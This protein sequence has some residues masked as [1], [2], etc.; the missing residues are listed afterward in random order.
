MK[1]TVYLK[2]GNGE[3]I[4]FSS[5]LKD[6][7]GYIYTYCGI[8]EGAYCCITKKGSGVIVGEWNVFGGKICRIV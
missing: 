3:A 6:G 8:Q 4:S 1:Y 7:W 5:N 2:D